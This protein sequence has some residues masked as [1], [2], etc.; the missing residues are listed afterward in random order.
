MRLFNKLKERRNK[1]R[2]DAIAATYAS[3]GWLG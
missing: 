3:F 2:F 1:K